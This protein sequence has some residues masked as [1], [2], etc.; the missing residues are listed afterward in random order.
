MLCVLPGLDFE[1]DFEFVLLGPHL[2]TRFHMR[3]CRFMA[4]NDLRD[5]MHRSHDI[6]SISSIVAEMKRRFLV[7][8]SAYRWLFLPTRNSFLNAYLIT[9][10]QLHISLPSRIEKFYLVLTRLI[11]AIICIYRATFFSFKYRFY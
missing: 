9:C 4:H 10:F 2:A 5:R 1:L 3:F 7:C 6:S 8:R 11:M